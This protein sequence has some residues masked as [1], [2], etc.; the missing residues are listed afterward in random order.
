MSAAPRTRSV[1]ISLGMWWRLLLVSGMFYVLVLALLELAAAMGLPWRGG[2][3]GAAVL[4]VPLEAHLS[5]RT[6]ARRELR[7]DEQTRYRLAEAVILV[8][9]TLVL[10]F[11]WQGLPHLGGQLERLFNLEFFLAAGVVLGFWGLSN[12]LVGWFEDIEFH[13]LEKAPPIT[14]PEYDLWAGSPVRRV[15]HTAAFQRVV[16]VFLAGGVLILIFS[17]MA[18]VDVA[19][20]VDFG[21]GTIRALILHVLA[22][23][24]L[25][26]ALV[27]EARLTL[28]RTRWQHEEAEISAAVARRWPFLVTGL[29]LLVLAVALLLPVDYSVGLLEALGYAFNAAAGVIV[30][31]AYAFLYLVGLLLYPLRW[32]LS[33]GSGAE[34]PDMPTPMVV[35]ESAAAAG[36]DLP[37]L[38]VAKTVGMWAVAIAMVVYALRN[39]LREHRDTLDRF[40]LLSTL[41][42]GL[43]SL[44]EALV[45]LWRGAAQVGAT[46]GREVRSRLQ[47]RVGQAGRGWR[48]RPRGP[49]ETVRYYYLSLVQRATRAGTARRS[50][51]TPEEY[52]QRLQERLPETEVDL[53]AVTE[54]FVEARYSDHPI[55][56]A[57]VSEVRPHWESVRRALRRLRG[58][59]PPG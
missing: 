27:A 19:A 43:A 2:Y 30:A 44:L 25:G 23:F 15:Q 54:A 13:P 4:V 48:R 41:R 8:L 58:E 57:Y 50:H 51:Q 28:L 6:I 49:R 42:R 16:S 20:I 10:R 31:V 34:A 46:V 55:D 36:S 26:L 1:R 22:Y 24:V 12:A 53:Q 38:E 45:A 29:L 39:F 9:F 35:P 37:W 18:R 59:P 32:L 5:R 17:G 52:G 3:L 40:G 33:R 14:S 47:S 7:G 11:L 21:R 56:Q